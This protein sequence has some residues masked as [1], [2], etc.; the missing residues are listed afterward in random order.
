MKRGELCPV[1]VLV[2]VSG[3]PLNYEDSV[4]FF[5][6]RHCCR[7]VQNNL[8]MEQKLR[9]ILYHFCFKAFKDISEVF[10]ISLLQ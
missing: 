5:Q 6:E 2:F 8:K 7:L 9:L 4:F 10:K 3:P 1:A